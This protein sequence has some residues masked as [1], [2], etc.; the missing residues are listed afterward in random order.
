MSD[1]TLEIPGKGM[2][3][4][5]AD[6]VDRAVSDY[7]ERLIFAQHPENGQW[8]VFLKANADMDYDREMLSIHGY[9]VVPILGFDDIPGAD[10]AIRR[11]YK[12]DTVRHGEYILDQINAQ[13]EAAKAE[14]EVAASEGTQAAAEAFDWFKRAEGVN[15]QSRIFI[16]GKDF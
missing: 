14:R 15:S 8:C 7:D 6:K 16:P 4:L 10:E 3:N 12:A 13:N 11:L 9:N 2:V 1:L 5:T